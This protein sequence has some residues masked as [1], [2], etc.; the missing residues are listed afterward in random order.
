MHK[1]DVMR[2]RRSRPYNAVQVEFGDVVASR[3]GLVVVDSVA[4]KG[5]AKPEINNGVVEEN[6]WGSCRPQMGERVNL[7]HTRPIEM[8]EC[9]A[10]HDLMRIEVHQ[11]RL[12]LVLKEEI[13]I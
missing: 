2:G 1:K 7:R 5:M 6:E 9:L 11:M 12:I 8:G 4:W 13:V 3:M 10:G